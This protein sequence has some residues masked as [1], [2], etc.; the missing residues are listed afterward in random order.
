MKQETKWRLFSASVIFEGADSICTTNAD[1]VSLCSLLIGVSVNTGWIYHGCSNL[2]G[3]LPPR[4]RISAGF[5]W[6]A[7]QTRSHLSRQLCWH[8]NQSEAKFKM[9]QITAAPSKPE[10]RTRARDV[11]RASGEKLSIYLSIWKIKG[12]EENRDTVLCLR[13]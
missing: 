6:V 11:W 9:D 2:M 1:P 8:T 3:L 7:Q 5:E 4:H 13:H 10:P 12:W